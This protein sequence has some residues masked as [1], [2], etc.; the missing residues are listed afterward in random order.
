MA[1]AVATLLEKLFCEHV[2][3][4][5]S[6]STA[7]TCSVVF[8]LI[9][10]FRS[11]SH[12]IQNNADRLLSRSSNIYADLPVKESAPVGTQALTTFTAYVAGIVPDQHEIRYVSAQMK[13]Q[14][15]WFF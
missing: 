14:H 5:R 11:I 10:R 12:L 1:E 7:I 3:P 15:A 4:L 6:S 9:E 13:L 8:P 2:S